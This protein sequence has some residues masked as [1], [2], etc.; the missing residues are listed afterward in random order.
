MSI[1]STEGQTLIG[2]VVESY[3]DPYAMGRVKV[4]C[5]SI[6]HKNI[7]TSKLPWS[8]VASE[9]NTPNKHTR[10]PDVGSIVEIYYPPGTKS[11]GA[12]VVRSVIHGVHDIEA[13]GSTNG[14]I[15]G[16]TDR[17]EN[18]G[19]EGY[20]RNS[21]KTLNPSSSGP[22]RLNQQP[23]EISSGHDKSSTF[24]SYGVW[25]T[26]DNREGI[27]SSITSKG[28]FRTATYHR[29][30]KQA[31]M[32]HQF[33]YDI[34]GTTGV[35]PH[36]LGGEDFEITPDIGS[37]IEN[38]LLK[39]GFEN[40]C[41]NLKLKQTTFKT[42]VNFEN[43]GH[44]CIL[45]GWK[46]RATGELSGVTNHRELQDK[47]HLIQTRD[48]LEV[49]LKSQQHT[50]QVKTPFGDMQR[51]VKYNGEMKFGG[52]ES[53]NSEKWKFIENMMNNI[54]TARTSL[55]GSEVKYEYEFNGRKEGNSTRK[56][57]QSEVKSKEGLF[58]KNSVMAGETTLRMKQELASKI[59]GGSSSEGFMKFASGER[60]TMNWEFSKFMSG[61]NLST[62]T[63]H[64]LDAKDKCQLLGKGQVDGKA[65]GKVPG[66]I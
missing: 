35:E 43:Q 60:K 33:T 29:H 61:E 11:T 28:F 62:N 66:C 42:T 9:S 58:S 6:H 48:F 16:R 25:P 49:E 63:L 31:S 46:G 7:D 4:L 21:R 40:F 44:R 56:N 38:P 34:N 22:A 65:A 18:L 64:D 15:Q 47:L 55:N 30:I 3:G 14:P 5:P 54:P 17:K 59:I 41:N 36:P 32:W 53:V 26:L 39:K 23:K 8:L 2:I 27:D 37:G 20:I 57:K 50:T 51:E 10:P 52:F 45:G 12:G 19:K 1:S 13:I 24:V